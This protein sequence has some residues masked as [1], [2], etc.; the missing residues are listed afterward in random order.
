MIPRARWQQIQSLFEQLADVEI[1][2]RAA[3]LDKSCGD[4]TELRLVGDVPPRS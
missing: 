1:A 4:D 3:H 2:E